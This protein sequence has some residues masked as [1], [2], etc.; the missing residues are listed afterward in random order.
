MPPPLLLPPLGN[1]AGVLVLVVVESL[2]A[3]RASAG[4]LFA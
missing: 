3:E 2:Q 4:R 1:G